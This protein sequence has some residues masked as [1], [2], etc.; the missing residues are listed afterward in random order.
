MGNGNGKQQ[1]VL[2]TSLSQ[3]SEE[4]HGE[5]EGG[6]QQSDFSLPVGWKMFYI[7]LIFPRHV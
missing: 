1:G 6:N 3:S 2:K 4:G 5:N 7:G